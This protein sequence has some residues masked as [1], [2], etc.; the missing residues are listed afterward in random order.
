MKGSYLLLLTGCVALMGGCTLAPNYH[1]PAGPIPAQWPASAEYAEAGLPTNAPAAPDIPWQEFFADELLRHVIGTALTNNRDLR[2]AAL[3]VDR[4]RA[5]YGIQRGE[6]LPAVRAAGSGSKQAMPADLSSTGERHTSERYD[7]SLGVAAWEIDF[8]GRIQSL[9]DRALEE[10]LATEQARRSAQI[11][12]VSSVANAYLLLAADRENLALAETTLASQ[13]GAYDLIKRRCDLGLAPYVDLYRSRTQVETAR[14]D[15]AQFMQR[16]ALDQNAL[17]LLV[18]TPV[19]SQ[20]LPA[21]LT[22]I[23]PPRE[24]APGISSDA[25]LRRPD[26]LQAENLLKAANADIGAAR[27]TLFPRISLTAAYG[28]ASSELSGLFASGQTAWS[29]VPLVSMPIF[30]TRTWSA[31]TATRVQQKIIVAQYEKA[32][33]NAFKEVADTLAVRDT[34]GLQVSAQEAL[35]DAVRETYRLSA[36]RYDKGMDSYLS[37]LD[38]QRSLYSAQRGLVLLRLA[39]TANTVRLYS[40]LG[41]GWSEAQAP[42]TP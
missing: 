33:Q 15:V 40:V 36:S 5:I 1:R 13:Q 17:N 19:A 6:L 18:G 30:D 27:A 41:G 25:L 39:K 3:N 37:V 31:L 26:I 23:I 2:I 8:F 32:I 34:V 35:V 11:L 14:G 16:V 21:A 10:Y 22:N 42:G 28:T 29:F 20:L 38:A 4:A 9:K 12:L 7:V 24:V